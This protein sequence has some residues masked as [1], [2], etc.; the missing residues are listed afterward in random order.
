MEFE[1]GHDAEG[2]KKLQ[3][4]AV[5]PLGLAGSA[6][7]CRPRTLWVQQLCLTSILLHSVPAAMT[8]GPHMAHSPSSP[9]RECI[10]LRM[11]RRCT[12]HPD[13]RRGAEVLLEPL[14]A[15]C[16][17]ICEMS[18]LCRS[19]GSPAKSQLQQE[20]FNLRENIEVYVLLVELLY[21]NYRCN[22]QTTSPRAEQDPCHIPDICSLFPPPLEKSLRNGGQKDD[23]ETA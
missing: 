17:D 4:R 14:C 15:A 3:V 19:P 22:P 5:S 13:D 23:K 1:V 12:S 20:I 6:E 21:L 9:Q 8:G 18:F 16:L 7:P 2:L 10:G 11:E